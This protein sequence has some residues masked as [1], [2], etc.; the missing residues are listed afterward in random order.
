MSANIRTSR[1]DHRR[2]CTR[3]RFEVH[4][5]GRP[6]DVRR[7]EHGRVMLGYEVPGTVPPYWMD[8]SPIFTPIRYRRA[9]RALLAEERR[10]H[11]HE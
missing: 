3:P 8:L 4:E 2:Y 6:G 9:I 11:G 7:C 1:G 10:E 5:W